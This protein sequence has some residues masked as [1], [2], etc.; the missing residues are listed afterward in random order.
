MRGRTSFE[1]GGATVYLVG[2]GDDEIALF[3]ETYEAWGLMATLASNDRSSGMGTPPEKFKS[4][5]IRSRKLDIAL[6]KY[7]KLAK[8]AKGKAEAKAT[9]KKEINALDF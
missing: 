9:R 6:A 8:E 7:D 4:I 3:G 2:M 1:Q 5:T